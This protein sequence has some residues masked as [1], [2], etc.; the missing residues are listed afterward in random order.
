MGALAEIDPSTRAYLSGATDSIIRCRLFGH[1][2]DPTHDGYIVEGRGRDRVFTQ[3][4]ECLRCKTKGVDRFEPGTLDRINTRSYDYA[5]GYLLRERK[6]GLSRREVRQWVA[7]KM[8]GGRR[9][10][11]V[12]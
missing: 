7:E 3:T 8:T 5:E 10:R 12:S 6:G 11:R 9:L 1:A 2:W 4:V